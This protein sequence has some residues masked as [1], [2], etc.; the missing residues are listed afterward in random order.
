MTLSSSYVGAGRP[1]GRLLCSAGEVSEGVETLELADE[2]L[3]EGG[4][5]LEAEGGCDPNLEQSAI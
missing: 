1:F 2:V 5:L 3:V 4:I